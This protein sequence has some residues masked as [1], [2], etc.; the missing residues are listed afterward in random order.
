MQL[1]ALDR[2]PQ[3]RPSGAA[4]VSPA[5]NRV[6][7]VAPVNPSVSVSPPLVAERAP[8]PGVVN[9]I[10]ASP[11][12]SAEVEPVYNTVSD[13]ARRGSEAATA[14]KDWTIHRPEVV[15]VEDPPAKPIAQVLMDHLKTMWTAGASAV[16]IEQVKNQ[17]TPPVATAATE[18][19]GSLAK[20][21]LVYTPSRVRRNENV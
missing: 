12:R 19:P 17:L 14:P 6:I 16:Q 21:V 9:L 5:A 8:A 4:V 13:P 20:Q 7:P 1:P 10:Q 15:Q 2:I 18:V 11:A 3:Q